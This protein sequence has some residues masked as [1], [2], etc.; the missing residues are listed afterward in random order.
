APQRFGNEPFFTYDWGDSEIRYAWKTLT[1]GFGTQAIWLGPAQINPIIHSNNAPSYPKL[2]IGLR[3]QGITLPRLNWYLGD[4]ETRLWWGYLSESDYFDANNSND[5]N[6]IT[7]LS[8][9]YAP[10]YFFKGFTI[11][12]N[13]TMLSKWNDLDYVSAFTLFVPFMDKSAG[14]DKR[15]QRA[16]VVF[17][18]VFSKVGAELYFEWARN[19]FTAILDHLVQYPFHSQAYT[20]GFR[21]NFL[22]S[23][24]LQGELLLEITNL[25]SSRDFELEWPTTFYAHHIITQ[26]YTNRGQWLGAGTGTGGNSQ[27]LGF[28]IFYNK[29]YFNIFAQRQSI[30]NDYIWFMHMGEPIAV[31]SQ[32]EWKMKAQIS[33]G[34]DNSIYINRNLGFFSNIIFS[35]IYKPTYNE[36]ESP[37]QNWYFAVGIKT[38]I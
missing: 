8:I 11:G 1:I 5:H 32:D 29:G 15:D 35:Y 30:D 6:L 24:S 28:A 22:F 26:G 13:R 27:Y 20:F 25:E 31:K 3:K 10:P 4:I 21:K 19:D 37:V 16:S 12:I 36:N 17:S 33:F 7:G 9:A 23:T 34:V 14:E 18:Y 38:K 2:D